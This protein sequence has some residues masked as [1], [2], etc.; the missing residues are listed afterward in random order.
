[1]APVHGLG[2]ATTTPG[3]LLA[4]T[5]KALTSCSLGRS[6]HA[7]RT[8]VAGLTSPNACVEN[9]RIRVQL[10]SSATSPSSP[11]SFARTAPT[12]VLQEAQRPAMFPARIAPC[13]VSLRSTA[14]TRIPRNR[15][16]AHLPAPDHQNLARGLIAA[17]RESVT[18]GKPQVLR[19]Q[20]VRALASKTGLQ[21]SPIKLLTSDGACCSVLFQKR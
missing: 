18:L 19:R 12:F 7:S 10:G 16:L 20:T 9:V 13:N 17:A 8:S 11:Y 3:D 1:M 21:A 14:K 6:S 2:V 15:H 5:G 4:V